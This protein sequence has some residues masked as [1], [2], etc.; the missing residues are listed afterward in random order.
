MLVSPAPR[1]GLPGVRA[2]GGRQ[3]ETCGQDRARFQSFPGQ[4]PSLVP[5]S[6]PR[7]PIIRPSAWTLT[8]AVGSRPPHLASSD[9]WSLLRVR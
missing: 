4:Q 1:G 6:R 5:V 9:I 8:L 2:I 3:A 7:V